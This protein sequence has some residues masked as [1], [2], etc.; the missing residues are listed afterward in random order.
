MIDGQCPVSVLAYVYSH[1]ICRKDRRSFPLFFK[2]SNRL[3]WGKPQHYCTV[4]VK[5][6][7]GCREPLVAMT[8]TVD[9]VACPAACGLAQT[10]RLQPVH[11]LS[12]RTTI[13]SMSICKPRRFFQPMQQTAIA[14][15]EPGNSG[16]EL[17]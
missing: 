4:S 13:A 2:V 1:C 6:V 16:L 17:P 8:V 10:P 11:R 9:A 15:A 14:S 7:V 5:L 12:P 3:E